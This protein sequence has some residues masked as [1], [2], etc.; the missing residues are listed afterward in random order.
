MDTKTDDAVLLQKIVDELLMFAETEVLWHRRFRKLFVV[1]YRRLDD[2]QHRLAIWEMDGEEELQ[3][4]AD[5]GAD[6][7][8]G[9]EFVFDD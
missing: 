8:T 7:M 2:A 9:I 4:V 1:G 6:G 5:F 3:E